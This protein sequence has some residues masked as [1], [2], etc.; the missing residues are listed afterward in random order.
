MKGER[1]KLTE[2][3]ETKCSASSKANKMLL[4]VIQSIFHNLMAL[5]L[6]EQTHFLFH[7]VDSLLSTVRI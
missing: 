1:I 2:T 7:Q 3:H 6:P 4:S 5:F